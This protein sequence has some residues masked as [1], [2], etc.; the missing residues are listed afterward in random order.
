MRAAAAS[1]WA[2]RGGCLSRT[3]TPGAGTG[4]SRP[5]SGLAG[6][7]GPQGGLSQAQPGLCTGPPAVTVIGRATWKH[8]LLLPKGLSGLKSHRFTISEFCR[9]KVQSQGVCRTAF[10]L[11]TSGEN[12][13]LGVYR[14]PKVTHIRWLL[15]PLTLTSASLG[16]APSL[17]LTRPPPS[18]KDPCAP[19]RPARLAQVKAPA[20]NPRLNRIHP[21]GSNASDGR[22]AEGRRAP[23]GHTH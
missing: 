10:L 12:L 9:S 19:G 22:D 20:Q 4:A 1:A 21:E 3:P 8:F 23:P 11:E 14:L 2:W 7:S 16:T 6:G 17:T 5:G 15:S 13:F 18:Y